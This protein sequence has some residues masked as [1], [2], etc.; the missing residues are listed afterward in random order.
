MAA[1]LSAETFNTTFNIIDH[2]TEVT[3][4]AVAW[5][6]MVMMLV[7]CTVVAMRYFFESGSLA[8]QEFATYLHAAVFMLGAAFTLKRNGH[9]RVDIFYRRWSPRKQ[10]M[11]DLFGGLVFLLP[12]CTLFL[13][14]SW[15]YVADSWAIRESSS[16]PGGLPTVYLLKTLLLIMPVLL[17]IQGFS[18][19][20]KNLLTNTYTAFNLKDEEDLYQKLSESVGND[21]V[22]DLYLDS[23]RRLTSG[24][25]KGSEVTVQEVRVLKVSD[26]LEGAGVSDEFSYKVEWVV[27]ARVRHLQHLHRRKNKYSGVLK[28][29]V[30]DGNWKIEQV[31]LESEERTIVPERRV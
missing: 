23:R 13:V 30:D 12:L 7:V 16:E 27:T 25:R 26:P 20:L 18:Q 8:L 9:V 1:K 29:R 5:L 19:I 2:F 28:I 22:E 4:Q 14:M 24:V 17:L 3:G 31:D 6:T 15:G 10:A 11:V 21:L